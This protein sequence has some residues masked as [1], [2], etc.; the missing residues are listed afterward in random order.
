MKFIEEG[1]ND[2]GKAQLEGHRPFQG[3][4]RCTGSPRIERQRSG[5][6]HQE[7]QERLRGHH[8]VA[9]HAAGMRRVRRLDRGLMAT[10]RMIAKRSPSGFGAIHFTHGG[11]QV[12]R[13]SRGLLNLPYL[14]L[15]D[16]AARRSPVSG[17]SA[18]A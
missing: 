6:A 8:D 11:D 16:A 18:R 10:R 7:P 15:R 4:P 9:R 13:A 17:R 1:K 12:N 3:Y 2:H 14:G 5:T